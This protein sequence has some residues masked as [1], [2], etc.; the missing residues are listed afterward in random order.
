MKPG[1]TF[2]PEILQPLF[3][4]V[5]FSTLDWD[6]DRDLIVRRILQTG[7]WP[8]VRWL[9]SAWGDVALR[10]WLQSHAGG[11]LNPRQ[12]RYWELVLNL[13]AQEVDRWID[14]AKNNPWGRRV[15]P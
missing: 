15:Q 2:L 13:P 14:R 7:N 8:A 6:S 3:W 10:A 4:D 9:R 5:E 1:S 11:R 12:L